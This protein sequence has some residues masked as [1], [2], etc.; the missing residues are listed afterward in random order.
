M[1]ITVVHIGMTATTVHDDIIVAIMMM[2]S[3]V[4]SS[5]CRVYLV[6]EHC[7]KSTSFTQLHT[8]FF[9]TSCMYKTVHSIVFGELQTVAKL[10]RVLNFSVK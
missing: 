7:H 1:R 2:S 5:W 6:D 4:L 9:Q 3:W 10:S 8:V